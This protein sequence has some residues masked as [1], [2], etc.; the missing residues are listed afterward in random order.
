MTP[1]FR[2][3][4]IESGGINIKNK[5]KGSDADGIFEKRVVVSDVLSA[6]FA[7]YCIKSLSF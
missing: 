6:I 4:R 1:F 7:F 3:T 2:L 5:I